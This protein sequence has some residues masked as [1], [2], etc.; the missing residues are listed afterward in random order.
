MAAGNKPTSMSAEAFVMALS[1]SWSP[2]RYAAVNSSAVQADCQTALASATRLQRYRDYLAQARAYKASG[3]G[4]SHR[5]DTQ[6]LVEARSALSDVQVLA[7]STLS[8]FGSLSRG[9]ALDQMT[10]TWRQAVEVAGTISTLDLWNYAMAEGTNRNAIRAAGVDDALF[11]ALD[12][13]VRAADAQV[14]AVGDSLQVTGQVNGEP[15]NTS[16]ATTPRPARAETVPDLLTRGRF[17]ALSNALRH[18]EPAYL[19]GVP[20]VVNDVHAEDVA[21]YVAVTAC[22]EGVR[23]VRK[24]EDTGLETYLGASP[25]VIAAIIIV[26][27]IVGLGLAAEYCG[28]QGIGAADHGG[29]DPSAQEKCGLGGLLSFLAIILILLGHGGFSQSPGST[30]VSMGSVLIHGVL[31]DFQVS[32]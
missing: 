13:A 16:L 20:L 15:V 18:G 32:P 26:A 22:Q 4:V 5:I 28:K 3:A 7:N 14:S 29:T 24:L 23:H 30:N 27:L 17:A 9:G 10:E 19:A 31:R 2:F 11:A 12:E 21:L 1:K 8:V 25:G 6:V